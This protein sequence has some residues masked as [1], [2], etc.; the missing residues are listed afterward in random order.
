MAACRFWYSEISK[1][2]GQNSNEMKLKK[3]KKNQ[4]NFVLIKCFQVNM[5]PF[6]VLTDSVF[7][8]KASLSHSVHLKITVWFGTYEKTSQK[9]SD[10]NRRLTLG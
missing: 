2:E 9:T 8:T 10:V 5:K 3:Q 4:F 6:C 1:P 7:V